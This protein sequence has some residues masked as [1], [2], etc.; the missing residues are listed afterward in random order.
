MREEKLPDP[1]FEELSGELNV[2]I[3]GPGEAFQKAIE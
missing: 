1:I 2:T 3:M